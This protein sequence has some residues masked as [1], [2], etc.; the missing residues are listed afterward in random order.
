MQVT[1]T[2]TIQIPD[3]IESINELEGRIHIFGLRLMREIL[4]EVWQLCQR[5]RWACEVCGSDRITG[6]GYRDYGVMTVFGRVRLKRHRVKCHECTSLSQPADS[7]LKEVRGGHA[8]IRFAELASL[9]GASW[10]YE[11]AATVLERM[12]GDKVS[13]EQVRRLTNRHGQDA[14]EAQLR[15]ADGALERHVEPSAVVDGPQMVNVAIDGGW[16]RSRDNPNG[17]EGK[18]GVV[19][20]ASE[21]V[22]EHRRSLSGRRYAATFGSSE[23]A[24]RLIYAQARRQGIDHAAK[25]SVI[26]DGTRW[27]STIAEEHFPY[28]L[29]ILDLWHIEHRVWRSV[30]A[31]I[32][33]QEVGTVCHTLMELLVRGRTEEALRQLVKLSHRYPTDSLRE[34]MTYVSNNADWIGDY[35]RL[36]SEGYPVGS[37]AV[38]K[39]VDIVINRRLK[40]RRG[41]SWKRV[42]ADQVVA[43]RVLTLNNDWDSM[44]LTNNT[45]A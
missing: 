43:L 9:S 32:A 15:E 36:R 5:L 33:R 2:R 37:G 6:E 34:L 42:C 31:S 24:G 20:V 21:K 4:C 14:V 1:I 18:V 26:G 44:W 41:M 38:E 11:Q 13:H 39:A 29:R 35:D 23:R 12:V 8:S 45:A 3:E 40:G 22:G 30:R 17:M 7:M 28:A 16:A 27:I 25:Q 19:Y 10:P